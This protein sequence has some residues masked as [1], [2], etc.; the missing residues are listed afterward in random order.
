MSTLSYL[1]RNDVEWMDEM[2]EEILKVNGLPQILS[3]LS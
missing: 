3:F 1:D 2:T